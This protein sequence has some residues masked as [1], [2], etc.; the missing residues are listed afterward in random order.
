MMNYVFIH[1]SRKSNIKI[2]KY[3]SLLHLEAQLALSEAI[4]LVGLQA[5]IIHNPIYDNIQGE[6]TII[7]KSFMSNSSTLKFL[8][9]HNHAHAD[10]Y[11]AKVFIDHLEYCKNLETLDL[12]LMYLKPSTISTIIKALPSLLSLSTI[13]LDRSYSLLY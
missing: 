10:R 11:P 7:C 9:L 6:S 4:G 12:A 1:N 8:S 5:I 2:M 13:V 3:F